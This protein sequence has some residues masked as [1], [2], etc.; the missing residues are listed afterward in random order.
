M[1]TE[2][3]EKVTGEETAAEQA[4]ETEEPIPP[5]KEPESAKKKKIKRIVFYAV[6][7][8]LA[9]IVSALLSLTVFFKIDEIYVEGTKKYPENLKL[10]TY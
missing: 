9:V 7:L 1:N 10:S 5:A 4:E 6:T 2:D 8:T 3:K